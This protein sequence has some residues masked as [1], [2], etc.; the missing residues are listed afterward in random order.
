MLLWCEGR[1]RERREVGWGSCSV[2]T[3]VLSDIM[4]N[5]M[6][7]VKMLGQVRPK[8]FRMSSLS[9]RKSRCT[10][11][12]R[13]VLNPQVLYSFFPSAHLVFPGYSCL[14]REWWLQFCSLK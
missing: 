2:V 1:E 11:C 10:T 13:V 14:N 6:G 3:A 12:L 8:S 9:K 7:N 4:G 5:V